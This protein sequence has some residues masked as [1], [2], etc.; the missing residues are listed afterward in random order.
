[1]DPS[2]P[3]SA[4]NEE[5]TSAPPPT[6]ENGP[7]SPTEG[8]ITI[9]LDVQPTGLEQ[10]A[11]QLTAAINSVGDDDGLLQVTPELIQQAVRVF[12]DTPR[13]Q[14]QG[15]TELYGIRLRAELLWQIGRTLTQLL[16]IEPRTVLSQEDI[17]TLPTRE[18]EDADLGEDGTLCCGICLDEVAIGTT[19]TYLPGCRH[20]F[21]HGCLEPWLQSSSTCPSCRRSAFP[22]PAE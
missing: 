4:S 13:L 10:I 11:G 6:P 22:E 12:L 9:V 19:V 18:I 16:G 5:G 2:S 14:P 21:H 8:E 7:A 17:D 15:D 3:S 1:M 20:W